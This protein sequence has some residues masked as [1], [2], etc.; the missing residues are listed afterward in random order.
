MKK[1]LGIALLTGAMMFAGCGDKDTFVATGLNVIAAPVCAPDAY[2]G[3]SNQTL[4]VT[5]ANGV[6]AN[7]SP[8]GGTLTFQTTSAN[9]GTIAGLADGSFTYTPATNFVG[10][11]TF[12]YTLGNSGGVVT[13]TVTITVQAVN[14]YFVDATNGDDGTGSFTNGLPFATIQ[15]AL[16]AAP[17]G[18]DVVV[19]PGSYTGTVTLE[20]GDRLLGSGSVL[21]QGVVRPTLTGPVVM[22]DGC[23]LDFLRIANSPGDCVDAD[24]QNGGTV[25]NCEL[26]TAGGAQQC[27]SGDGLSGS[28]TV[29]DS[30]L[31]NA[32]GGGI[33]VQ[34][35]GTSQLTMVV[36]NNIVR[37]NGTGGIGFLTNGDS[38]ANVSAVGNAISG[39]TLEG[40][41][42]SCGANSQFCLDLESNTNDGVYSLFFS[43]T[44][45]G[46]FGVEELNSL[47]NPAPGGAG[48][49]G[50]VDDNTGV[51][52]QALTPL[53][54]GVCGF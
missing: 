17:A 42:V 6:L 54:D 26:D 25:T 15:A 19:R 12:T 34:V 4:T 2:T 53:L 22:A 32:T 16:A 13:C 30:T 35:S 14:G 45:T 38:V 46:S 51:G 44:A 40:F 20:N 27:F 29:S 49:T 47:T 24:G 31:E 5:A 52:G 1:L 28:W 37:N 8:A 21:A 39:N 41:A 48:N 43:P 10:T 7:D 33:G 3:S 9:N 36:S 11:D 18:S 50:T 23:T